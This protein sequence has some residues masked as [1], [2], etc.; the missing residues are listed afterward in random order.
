MDKKRAMKWIGISVRVVATV[1][2][3]GLG[4]WLKGQFFKGIMV[5]VLLLGIAG[6]TL[7]GLPRIVLFVYSG[8]VLVDAGR[9]R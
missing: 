6:S 3:P 5:L 9:P 4:H 2:V 8:L 7:I 1:L